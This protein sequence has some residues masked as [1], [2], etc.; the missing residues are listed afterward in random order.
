LD[1]HEIAGPVE[2]AAIKDKSFSSKD[3]L[4]VTFDKTNSE[5]DF[6]PFS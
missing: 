5:R 6:N 1:K 2:V 3:A 4:R